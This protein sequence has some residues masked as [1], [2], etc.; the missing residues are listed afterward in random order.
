MRPCP[1]PWHHSVYQ[2]ESD[3]RQ[4]DNMNF[5]DLRN[6]S[7]GF[8]VMRISVLIFFHSKTNIKERLNILV[9]ELAH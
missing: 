4:V 5:A 7:S 2:L 3:V 1:C 9:Q 8:K 6:Q